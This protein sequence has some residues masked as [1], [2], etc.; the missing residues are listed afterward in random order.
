MPGAFADWSPS[1]SAWLIPALGATYADVQSTKD[2]IRR[3]GQE[4]NPIYGTPHPSGAAL[5]QGGLAGFAATTLG[6]GLLSGTSRKA[7]L[8]GVTGLEAGLAYQNT[9]VKGTGPKSSFNDALSVPLAL[10]I[11][12]ALFVNSLMPNLAPYV[13][14]ATPG[15]PEVGISYTKSF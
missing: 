14:S 13:K 4:T 8:A 6:A 7:L 3:G 10:G 5:D 1:D 12:S 11:G 2:L 9:Q 15:K